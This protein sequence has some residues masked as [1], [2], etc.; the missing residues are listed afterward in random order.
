[1]LTRSGRGARLALDLGADSAGDTHGT[2]PEPLDGAI[3]F[4]PAGELVPTALA[5]LDRGGTLAI[6][7]ICLTDIPTLRYDAHLF[8]ERQLRSVTA[9]TREDGEEFLA[10]AAAIGIRVETTPYPLS[11]Q[12]GAVGPRPRPVRGAVVLEVAGGLDDTPR[13]V[14]GC[15]PH[16][17]RRARWGTRGARAPEAGRAVSV[18]RRGPMSRPAG[19]TTPRNRRR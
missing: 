9:N 17:R 8:Q 3:L 16:R 19:R 5:A 4:A 2:P 10:L 12:P 6:A 14:P 7:G 18:S 11:R 13:G 1:M 15:R